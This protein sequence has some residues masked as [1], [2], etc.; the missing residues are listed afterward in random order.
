MYRAVS[1]VCLSAMSR[2]ACIEPA[3]ASV[4]MI[5]DIFSLWVDEQR[6]VKGSLRAGGIGREFNWMKTPDGF[7]V[8]T[9]STKDG[10]VVETGYLGTAAGAMALVAL[11]PAMGLDNFT[12]QSNE[13]ASV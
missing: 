2:I 6:F 9:A 4:T 1:A 12:G 8:F 5:G 3:P 11:I 7:D 10:V 13:L